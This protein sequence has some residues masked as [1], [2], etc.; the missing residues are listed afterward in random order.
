[1]N[2][3]IFTRQELGT[4]V[5]ALLGTTKVELRNKLI[6]AMDARDVE[7]GTEIEL[8]NKLITAMDARDITAEDA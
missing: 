6:T 5:A 2:K 3:L 7:D 8:R 1:M 4:L